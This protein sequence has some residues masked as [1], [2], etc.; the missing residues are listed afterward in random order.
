VSKGKYNYAVVPEHPNATS[1]GYV[2]EHRVVMENK[3][4]R[5]LHKNEVVH[6]K[7]GDTKDNTIRNL[8]LKTKSEHSREH[9]STGR[10]CVALICPACGKRFIRSYWHTHLYRGG[11]YT[12]CSRP[13]NGKVSTEIQN[14]R[15]SPKLKKAIRMNVIRECKRTL[16]N[17]YQE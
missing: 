5:L 8:S 3:L 2:L 11:Q 9:Q 10:R 1:K 13:C 12:A 17:D 6:H 7:N 4:G 15:I 16:S 14:N